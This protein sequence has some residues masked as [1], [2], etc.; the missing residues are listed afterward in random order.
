MLFLYLLQENKIDI[1]FFEVDNHAGVVGIHQQQVFDV[2]R[3]SDCLFLFNILV[4][5]TIITAFSVSTPQL[6]LDQCTKDTFYNDLQRVMTKGKDQEFLIF[7]G[8]WNG[9]TIDFW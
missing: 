7:S 9:H 6:G 1:N 3:G 8:D 2:N 5:E 4:G